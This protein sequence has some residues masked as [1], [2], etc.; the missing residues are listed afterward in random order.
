MRVLPLQDFF[1]FIGNY[2]NYSSQK[3][4]LL[5]THPNCQSKFFIT[6]YK[7]CQSV[8]LHFNY[9]NSF[10]RNDNFLFQIYYFVRDNF[11]SRNGIA[12]NFEIFFRR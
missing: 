8:Q 9:I 12:D 5:F 4:R 6:S 10:C 1:Y 11:F 3:Y 2:Y 7:G